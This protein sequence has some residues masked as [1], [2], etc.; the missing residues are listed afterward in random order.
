MQP[1]RLLTPFVAQVIEAADAILGSCNMADLS[2]HVAR[3]TQPPGKKAEQKALDE[4]KVAVIEA[5]EAKL[6]AR[7]SLLEGFLDSQDGTAFEQTQLCLM[8]NCV[9]SSI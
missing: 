7:L 9:A 1:Q 6:V 2:L 3:K 8:A 4:Q 5:F